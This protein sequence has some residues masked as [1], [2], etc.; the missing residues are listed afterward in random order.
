M[1]EE[2]WTSDVYDMKLCRT[3]IEREGDFILKHINM[4]ILLTHILKL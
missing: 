1:T 2:S 4:L 3:G